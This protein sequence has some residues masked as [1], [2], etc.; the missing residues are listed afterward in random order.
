MEFSDEKVAE[1]YRLLLIGYT[2]VDIQKKLA[3]SDGFDME[4]ADTLIS[5]AQELLLS[6]IKE[7]NM[8]PLCVSR[9]EDLYKSAREK[10]DVKTCVTINKELSELFHLKKDLGDKSSGV[11]ITFSQGEEKVL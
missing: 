3:N 6:N 9:Y 5:E 2:R 1:V 11:T 10:D 4:T 7:Q 8:L